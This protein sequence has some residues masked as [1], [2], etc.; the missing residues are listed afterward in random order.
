MIPL[1][2]LK[3]LFDAIPKA[4]ITEPIYYSQWHGKEMPTFCSDIVAPDGANIGCVNWKLGV[5]EINPE[6]KYADEV[7]DRIGREK[8]TPVKSHLQV[9]APRIEE[10]Y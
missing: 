6:Y 5:I 10:F 8:F 2:S 1:N 4:S 9:E 3:N 7:I